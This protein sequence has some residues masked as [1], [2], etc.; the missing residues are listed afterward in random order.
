MKWTCSI[1]K[2]PYGVS[3]HKQGKEDNYICPGCTNY[4]VIVER[5]KKN[6]EQLN[7]KMHPADRESVSAHR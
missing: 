6:I 4:A 2:V 1:C 5:V 7:R 3:I